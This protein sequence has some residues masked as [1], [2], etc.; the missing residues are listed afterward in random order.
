MAGNEML[1]NVIIGG[2]DTCYGDSGGPLWVMHNR[3]AYL[4]GLVSRGRGCAQ[5]NNVGIY[6]RYEVIKNYE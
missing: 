1:Q 3:K 6:T 5:Q 4:V 2:A